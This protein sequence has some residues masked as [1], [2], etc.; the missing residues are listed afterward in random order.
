ME[1]SADYLSSAEPYQP[2]GLVSF[3]E[4]PIKTQCTVLISAISLFTV[5]LDVM[6]YVLSHSISVKENVSVPINKG[7]HV[8]RP[9]VL[10]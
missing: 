7:L 6:H 8:P 1:S 2:E 5:Y 10:V 9:V 4:Q 3:I